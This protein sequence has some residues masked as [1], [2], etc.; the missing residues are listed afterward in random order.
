[1]HGD[2]DNRLGEE[3]EVRPLAPADTPGLRGLIERCYGDAYPKRVVYEPDALANLIRSGKYSG[4][5][6]VSGEDVVGHMAYTWPDPD[7]HP[8]NQPWILFWRELDAAIAASPGTMGTEKLAD[9]FWG[10]PFNGD[11]GPQIHDHA[12]F[13]MPVP[14]DQLGHSRPAGVRG[15]VGAI[16]IE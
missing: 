11:D 6:A 14:I 10:E 1:M 2:T 3:A 16:E 13:V 5:V 8:E 12:N 15:D 4:V 7:D 9:D